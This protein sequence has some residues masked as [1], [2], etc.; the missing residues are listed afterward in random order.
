MIRL[1]FQSTSDIITNS[2]SEVFQLKS[3]LTLETIREMIKA[4]GRKN[5]EACPD[6]WWE[7][8]FEEQKKF[9]GC[10]G[11]GGELSF[12]NWEDIYKRDAEW[13]VVASKREQYTPEIWALQYEENLD[14]LK[15]M[16][17]VNI[18]WNRYATIRFILEN[19][20]VV[21][22]DTYDHYWQKD[23]ETGKRI[24]VITKEMYDALPENCRDDY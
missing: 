22:C 9:D 13:N 2:S 12:Y 10:S 14:E 19:F 16:I 24:R 15:S 6:E 3:D 11:E 8:P 23:P 21:G 20:W 4:E 17:W 5:R 18:D 7:L 1:K